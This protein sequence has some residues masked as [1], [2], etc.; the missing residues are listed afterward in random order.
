[1]RLTWT[2]IRETILLS[3]KRAARIEAKTGPPLLGQKGSKMS[4]EAIVQLVAVA[5]E[6]FAEANALAEKVAKSTGSIAK[7]VKDAREN[8]DDE[9][10]AKFRA[11]YEK[12]QAQINA[13]VEEINKY[14]VDQKIVNADT[15]TEDEVSKAK[16]EWKALTKAAKEAWGAAETVAGIVGDTM[17]EK[18]ETLTFSGKA[19]SAS[20]ATGTGGRRLRFA[21]VE[22]NGQEVKN[23]SAVSQKIYSDS[24]VRVSAADLQKAL[25]ESAGTDDVAKIGDHTFGWS[26]TDAD[27]NTH[28]YDVTV[29][30]RK[31][32][33]AT[34]ED[35]A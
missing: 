15:M 16:D 29:Y 6:K 11:W 22:V 9:T 20:G 8:S 14:I 30:A 23:L 32:D 34:E 33:D 18:P 35:A 1:M 26:E 10:V 31:D 7:D 28:K 17:P 13:K 5:T 4:N 3:P 21:R 27:G 2:P 24:K 25:F 19:S 12:A